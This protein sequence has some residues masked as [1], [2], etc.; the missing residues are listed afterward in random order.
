[1]LPFLAFLFLTWSVACGDL[2]ALPIAAVIGSLAAQTHLSYVLLVLSLGGWA[3]L[4]LV[5]ELRRRSAQDPDNWP[6]LRRRAVRASAWSA[7]TVAVCWAQPLAEQLFGK[8]QGNL[9]RIVES[10]TG[11]E[12]SGLGLSDATRVVADVVAVPPGWLPPSFEKPWESA[13]FPAGVPRLSVAVLGLLLVAGLLAICGLVARRTRDRVLG[14]AAATA[15][16]AL[17]AGLLN[18]SRAPL[19]VA[20][21]PLHHFRW[22]WPLG[23]FVTFTLLTSVARIALRSVAGRQRIAPV[24]AAAVAVVAVVN[25]PA[26]NRGSQPDWAVPVMRRVAKELQVLDG[27]GPLFMRSPRFDDF[28][29]VAILAELRRRGI[30][31]TVDRNLAHQVGESR[32]STGD[33]AEA[34]LTVLL[35]EAGRTA[36]PPGGEVL[37]RDRGPFTSSE[38]GEVEDLRRRLLRELG[39]GS[40]RTRLHPAVDPLLE[41]GDYPTLERQRR[42]GVWDPEALMASGE[43]LP[44]A[45]SGLVVV[46]ADE[47][48]L[49]DRLLPLQQELDAGTVTVVITGIDRDKA[50]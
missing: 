26:S 43:L 12:G 16:V 3:A 44:L 25:V 34:E 21:V 50:A 38:R 46:D 45:A 6:A 29:S 15:G 23:A 5:L 49:V 20:G 17:V 39:D 14:A 2:P 37:L 8:G 30:P 19:T 35:G 24:V 9:S 42:S 48:E 28:F 40:I 27:R 22:L 4:G 41:R 18:A 47:A 32:R 1:V 33:D 31:F 7:A 13:Y 11:E 10:A 36:I